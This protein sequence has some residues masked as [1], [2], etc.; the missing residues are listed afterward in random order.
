MPHPY[1]GREFIHM[2]KLKT[3]N[4]K[5]KFMDGGFFTL[6]LTF[7][8]IIFYSRIVDSEF[9]CMFTPSQRSDNQNTTIMKTIK[10]T[11]TETYIV[12]EECIVEVSNATFKKLQNEDSEE[13][14]RLL[15]EMNGVTC[16]IESPTERDQTFMDIEL[17]TE[18]DI[19]EV[20][21][22]LDF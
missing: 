7:F 12:T 6:V 10:V 18:K 15:E 22:T 3:A 1:R 21:F 11:Y 4:D 8:L 16:A 9:C 5:V 2:A 13:Y 14:E 20:S 19:E 17:A